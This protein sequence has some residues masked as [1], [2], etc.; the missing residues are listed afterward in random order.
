MVI[1]VVIMCA[2]IITLVTRYFFGVFLMLSNVLCNITNKAV[3]SHHLLNLKFTFCSIG[4]GFIHSVLCFLKFPQ[5]QTSLVNLMIAVQQSN[6]RRGI[7]TIVH[8]FVV[9]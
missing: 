7:L 5:I 2:P 1:I 6:H 8:I 4:L 3:K 9:K